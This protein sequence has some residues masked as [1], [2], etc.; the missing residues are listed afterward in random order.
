MAVDENQKPVNCY[1]FQV[2]LKTRM[3]IDEFKSNMFK[4]TIQAPINM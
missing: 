4:G 3:I 2:Y 1:N